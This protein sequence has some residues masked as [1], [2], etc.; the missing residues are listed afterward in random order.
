MEAIRTQLKGTDWM[1]LLWW[2][3]QTSSCLGRKMWGLSWHKATG[4]LGADEYHKECLRVQVRLSLKQL[5]SRQMLKPI[6][7]CQWLLFCVTIQL[8]HRWP[9]EWLLPNVSFQQ[10]CDTCRGPPRFISNKMPIGITNGLKGLYWTIHLDAEM[11]LPK[12]AFWF[13]HSAKWHTEKQKRKQRMR[14]QRVSDKPMSLGMLSIVFSSKSYREQTDIFSNCYINC[15][16]SCAPEGTDVYL[17]LLL[18]KVLW[19]DAC[20]IRRAVAP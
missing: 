11:P 2:G 14:L 15:P 8:H 18:F 5:G 4:Y 16:G 13:D 17:V 19:F 10:D 9:R 7:S 12:I 1:L 3:R 6:L 20:K